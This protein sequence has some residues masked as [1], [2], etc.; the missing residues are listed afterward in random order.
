[1]RR[2]LA[3]PVTVAAVLASVVSRSARA[4][5]PSDL[6]AALNEPVVTA[7]SQTAEDQSTAPA[8]VTTVT[9]EDLRRYGIKTLA[10]A[11]NFLSL[12]ML[13]QN[14]LDD[15]EI[16]SRGVMLT[17][18]YGDHVLLLINGHAVNEMWG[19]TAYFGRG[20][21]VP[22]ELIDHIEVILGPGSVLYGDNAMLGVINIVTKRAKD[23]EGLHFIGETELLTSGRGALGFGHEF[24]LFGKPAELT[25]EGEYYAQTG[26]AFGFKAETGIQDS[27][28]VTGKP[29]PECFNP[30]CTNPGVWGGTP[31]SNSYWTKLP[32]GYLRL[33]WGD[34]EVDVHAESYQRATPNQN[35]SGYNIPNNWERDRFLSADLRHRWAIASGVQLKSRI[36]GDLYDY[37]QSLPGY[38]PGDCYG[39]NGVFPGQSKGCFY[40][41][42]GSSRWVG[43]EEQF[44]VDWLHDQTLTTLLGTDD[45]FASIGSYQESADPNSFVV[46][47]PGGTYAVYS[48]T[49]YR[50]AFYGQQ[51]WRPLSWLGLNVG[52]RFD[53]DEYF[54]NR[55]SPRAAIAVS[56]WHNGTLKVIYSEAFRG[57][58]YYETNWTDNSTH[59]PNTNPPFSPGP[60]PETVRSIE[61][62]FEQRFGSQRVFVGA[63][64][65]QYSSLVSDEPAPQAAL[66]T[67][68][69][70]GILATPK[71]ATPQ[72][73][74][75]AYGPNGVG[76]SQYTNVS[77]IEDLGVNAAFEGSLMNRAL[78][79]GATG[80]GA[81]T[82][83]DGVPVYQGSGALPGPCTAPS[84]PAM[85][86]EGITGVQNCPLPVAP[87]FF[88]NARISY[89]LP[90]ELPVVAFAA[91][92]V[93]PRIASSG[94]T[95]G[96]APVPTAPTQVDLRWTLSGDIPGMVRLS[97]RFIID[98][99]V[100]AT[101]PYLAGP[102][103]PPTPPQLIPVDQ[104]RATL[105]LQYT[106]K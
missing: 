67:A 82:R 87:R 21:G 91:A 35:Y 52:A 1:M 48:A 81:F 15:V 14:N 31:A 74:Y 23:F 17:G 16:G 62:S 42:F 45:R 18:D 29:I 44:L 70:Q 46:P 37:Q 22:F 78:R 83:Q 27:D 98:Y 20:A 30:G 89:A 103:N 97:Y 86:Q 66:V 5:G 51:T 63:F 56:P 101:N 7:A 65:A 19:G 68:V 55:L 54:G 64:D 69:K 40:E 41:L 59:I 71:N 100:N 25:W 38:T 85:P 43:I 75:K 96:W 84:G 26:P 76:V 95:A 92:L 57:P 47:E 34:F 4:D 11:I 39:T 60:S 99:V 90:D 33:L 93:G 8:T 77:T 61:A 12:G 88:G 49:D 80:T 2:A 13:T 53:D 58:S 106:L 104:F 9:A 6:E 24:T 94:L 105:G 28:P 72:G 50:L 36:Y 3:V 102:A 79:Y 73:I 32:D 10:E